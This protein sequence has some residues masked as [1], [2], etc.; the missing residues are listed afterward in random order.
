MTR[1]NNMNKQMKSEIKQLKNMVSN[2]S[3]SKKKKST[4]NKKPKRARAPLP[5]FQ[6]FPMSECALKYATAISDPWNPNAEGA[7]IPTFPSRASQKAKGWI[8]QQV[9][10]GTAGWGFVM[11]TPCLSSNSQAIYYTTGTYAGSGQLSITATGVTNANLGNLSW[12]N[13]SL[14][15]SSTTPAAISG[16]LVSFGASLQY[17]GTVLNRGGMVYSLVE[18]NHGNLN[19]MVP[20]QLAAYQECRVEPITPKKVLIGGSGIDAQEVAYPEYDP[21]NPNLAIYPYC[22]DIS[23]DA[24]ATNVGGAIAAFVFTGVAGNTFEFEL[25]EHCEYV[26]ASASPMATPTHSD[27]RG[28]EMVNTASNRIPQLQVAHPGKSMAQLMVHAL[29]E[30]AQELKP[31]AVSAVK[32]LA[33][34]GLST[35]G[36]ALLGPVGGAAT[37]YTTRRMIGY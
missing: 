4:G 13:T 7:C 27:A 21:N 15:G 6:G 19:G 30:V 5:S 22:Q 34:A 17:S 9:T 8:R 26:G 12:N 11:V 25:V 24:T 1:N 32:S 14:A 31:V 16:R 29:G 28:F 36:S 3:V 10:I 2:I 33:T 37:S 35:I 23:I 20:S 18:P